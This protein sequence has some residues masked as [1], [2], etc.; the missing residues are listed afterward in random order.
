MLSERDVIK[1]QM[2][3]M[4]RKGRQHSKR[5]SQLHPDACKCF[6]IKKETYEGEKHR[7]ASEDKSKGTTHPID[8]LRQQHSFLLS[9][10]TELVIKVSVNASKMREGQKE[11]AGY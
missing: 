5:P 9:S 10:H 7:H 3:L 2:I 4:S 8:R 6:R 11:S 1:C